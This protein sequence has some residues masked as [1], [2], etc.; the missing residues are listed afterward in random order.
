MTRPRMALYLTAVFAASFSSAAWLAAGQGVPELSRVIEREE[1]ETAPPIDPV[2][3]AHAIVDARESFAESGDDLALVATRERYV[4]REISWEVRYVAPFCTAP[5]RCAV[6]PF[7]HARLGERLV[8]GW[9]PR[10][11]LGA[12]EYRE[13]Q[14]RC[15]SHGRC[16]V[17]LSAE[18][19]ELELSPSEPTSMTL[20]KV[21]I[22][23]ARD[24]RPGES[25]M[26]RLR[27][28]G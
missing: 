19:S 3:L 4:G 5:D 22:G 23:E 10:L 27:P 17:T 11:A 24:E 14:G 20:S 16:V 1:V 18:L 7:D 28:N 13:L 12:R 8:Q 25:W 26:R 21:R 6:L 9:M 2:E 15:A